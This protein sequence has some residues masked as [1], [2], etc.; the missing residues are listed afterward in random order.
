MTDERHVFV[1]PGDRWLTLYFRTWLATTRVAADQKNIDT[2]LP[3]EIV[4]IA[5]AMSVVDRFL[6]EINEI[7]RAKNGQK[8]QEYLVIE[9][10][11]PS[12]Y[13][14]IVNE[15]QQLFPTRKHDVL[16]IKCKKL[17]PEYDEG[18]STGG[19]WTAFITFMVQYFAFLRDV[20]VDQLVETHAMLQSLLKCVS[21]GENAPVHHLGSHHAVVTVSS[22]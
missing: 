22:H 15:L 19:S 14:V 7:L 2:G 21:P 16:E 8:L 1:S 5:S 12:L 18:E 6:A 10:P 11:L 9:P 20:N 4:D 3:A 17:L 13:S